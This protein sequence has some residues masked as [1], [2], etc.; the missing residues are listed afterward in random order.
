MKGFN[1]DILQK[2]TFTNA[3]I[4][5]ISGYAEYKRI[6]ICFHSTPTNPLWF[7]KI[8]HI[9]KSYD[10]PWTGWNNDAYLTASK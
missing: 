4:E 3:Q 8:H 1:V 10:M 7:S 9:H 2:D 5:K 6:A